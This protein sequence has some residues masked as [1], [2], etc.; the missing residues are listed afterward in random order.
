LSYQ[1]HRL[2]NSR[3][4][5]LGFQ[6]RKDQKDLEPEGAVVSVKKL[7]DQIVS[8]IVVCTKCRLYEGRRNAVPGEGSSKSQVIFVGEG[9]GGVEDVRGRPFVGPAGK[10]LDVLL[11]EASLDRKDVFICNIVRCRPPKNREPL[12][13]EVQACTPYLDRQIAAIQPG[14]I[15][16][17]GNHSTRYMFSKA[18]LPFD[19][20]TGAHGEFHE[21]TFENLRITVYP[22]FHP[23]AALYSGSYR[24]ML[25]E[26]FRLLRNRLEKRRQD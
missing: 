22:T 4:F 5:D 11:S 2:R 21:V 24:N 1:A 16:T 9:P 26:D 25:I 23:A 3:E 8:E 10:L 12:P 15:V 13:D 20:I 14:F 17:L 6:E 7:L 18:G 19:G